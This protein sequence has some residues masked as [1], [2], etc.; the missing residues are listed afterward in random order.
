MELTDGGL[1]Q[2]KIKGIIRCKTGKLEK[3]MY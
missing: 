3:S 2:T 1:S